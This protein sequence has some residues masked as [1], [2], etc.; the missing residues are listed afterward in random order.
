MAYG[1]FS[2]VVGRVF[3]LASASLI[4]T[5]T[6]A[7]AQNEKETNACSAPACRELT[8]ALQDPSCGSLQKSPDENCTASSSSAS[9]PGVEPGAPLQSQTLVKNHRLFGVLADYTTVENQDQFGRLSAKTK[10]RLSFKTMTDPVTV[11][12]L[13][14]LALMGQ[15]RNTYPAYGEGFQGFEKRYATT[16][17]NTGIGTLMTTSV[18]PTVLHQDPRYFQLG[19]GSK[20]QRLLYSVSRE[21]IAHTDSGKLQFNYSEVA[22]NAVAAGI[23]NTY[24]PQSQRTLDNT[25]NV[26][27]ADM[28]LNTLCNVAKEFWPDIRRKLHKQPP[29][30]ENDPDLAKVNT[31]PQLRAQ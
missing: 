27:G 20:L 28:L 26:W 10:F 11:S 3:L 2:L 24:L 8:A 30:S 6:Q 12:F 4:F 15:A 23:S 7:D 19:T 13:G 18:F 9:A 17:A 21:L 31:T 16:F 14:V 25:L 1:S 22:G 5:G 29:A